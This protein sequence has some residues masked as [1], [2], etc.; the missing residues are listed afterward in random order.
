MADLGVT[1]L[2]RQGEAQIPGTVLITGVVLPG[3]G[4]ADHVVAHLVCLVDCPHSIRPPR[5]DRGG[6]VVS[7]SG[8][9]LLGD[10]LP[11]GD[12]FQNAQDLGTVATL[13]EQGDGKVKGHGRFVL[14]WFGVGVFKGAP[15]P[16]VSGS[17]QHIILP[18][19]DAQD[20]I[21][22]QQIS[23]LIHRGADLAILIRFQD[24]GATLGSDLIN[25]DSAVGGGVVAHWFGLPLV[26]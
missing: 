17:D 13:A 18:T 7:G 24:S 8:V 21:I 16:I 9:T 19:G 1:V 20:L 26:D 3:S 10:A 23:D 2:F 14:V 4:G 22:E 15:V 12:T 25:A 11:I 6:S 5:A